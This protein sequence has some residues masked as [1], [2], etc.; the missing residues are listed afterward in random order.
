MRDYYINRLSPVG[1]WAAAWRMTTVFWGDDLRSSIMA[2][3]SKL[4]QS[5]LI[6]SFG[7]R[8]RSIFSFS[9]YA[10]LFT[11][12]CLSVSL[13]VI[14]HSVEGGHASPPYL[15]SPTQYMSV[16]LLVSVFLCSSISFSRCAFHL[17]VCASVYLFV[18]LSIL[19]ALI[20]LCLTAVLSVCLPISSCLTVW[21]FMC[22]PNWSLVINLDLFW[23]HKYMSSCHTAIST[24][25]MISSKMELSYLQCSNDSLQGNTQGVSITVPLTSCLT[26]LD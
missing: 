10:C 9:I 17:S 14:C 19:S 13:F 20:S 21:L 3:K 1:L 24:P 22:F 8:V 6:L 11:C 25:L 5:Q 12:V 15:S 7:W 2:S 4:E 26:G 23:K 18:S 16:Y